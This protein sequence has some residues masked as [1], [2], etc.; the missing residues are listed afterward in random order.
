MARRALPGALVTTSVLL[1]LPARA[2]VPP[3]PQL[4]MAA[5]A[6]RVNDGTG[7]AVVD[8]SAR[9]GT[10]PPVAD[11]RGSVDALDI[12]GVTFRLTTNR[13]F[14]FMSLKDVPATMRDTDSAYGYYLW[15]SS[16]PKMA[17]FDAVIVNPLHAQLGQQ[18]QG[19]PTG[20]VGTTVTGGPNPLRGLGGGVD[21][22]KDVVYVYADRDSLEEQ[23]G[24]PLADG[25]QITAIT[26]KTVLF[27]G[28]GATA[29]G[30]TQRPADRTDV[31]AATAVQTVG[32]DPC[33]A[34][35]SFAVPD[36]TAQ[37]GDPATLRATLTDDAGTALAA[38]RVTFQLAGEAPRA[39][40]TD[41]DGRVSVTLA[42]A[43]A[44]DATG[45]SFRYDGDELSGRGDVNSVLTVRQET[46][47]VAPLKVARSGTA[48][49]VTA[50]LTEDDPRPFAKQ[51]VDW[52]V[53]GK[54]VATVLTDAAG[55][56]VYRGAKAGQKVQARYAGAARRY[57][58]V[59]SGIVTA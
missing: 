16:G 51:P 18:P 19:Y 49:T 12:T 54:K 46:V 50:T 13:V 29:S 22:A 2:A 6:A 26:G 20:S 25:D 38:R 45:V 41:A 39:L 3:P 48:R 47:L 53:N 28:S 9:P 5:C 8:W 1:G 31:P 33:F 7:D 40:T 14:A 10:D 36:V 42:A 34:A 21:A 32:E 52:Y 37:Y 17:R 11:P 44:A 23:L 56:S 58:A 4:P 15:F 55:R 43:P 57:A 27:V 59:K 30:V 24:G 35:S